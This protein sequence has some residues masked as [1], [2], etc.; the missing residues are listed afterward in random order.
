MEFSRQEYWRGY[1]FPSPWD[2]D[3]GNKPK[4]PALQ[5]DSLPSEQQGKPFFLFFFTLSYITKQLTDCVTGDSQIYWKVLEKIT[6]PFLDLL[7]AINSENKSNSAYIESKKGT[8]L[9]CHRFY[10]CVLFF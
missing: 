3:L 5:A 1:P 10:L 9:Q 2:P 8:D 6:Y 4:S 7:E